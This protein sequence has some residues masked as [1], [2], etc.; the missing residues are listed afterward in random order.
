MEKQKKSLVYL[1]GFM[2]SGKSTIA[3]ILA[4]TIGYDTVDIDTE[5]EKV[6]GKKVSEI[7]SD[8]GEHFF[9]ETERKLL[10]EISRRQACVVSLG[11]GT[12][13]NDENLQLVKATGVLV[14]LKTDIEHII[15][16]MKFKR[17][18]PLLKTQEGS[19]L[20][21]DELRIR[22]NFLLESREPFYNQAD[23]T[24]PT[25]EAR[26]GLTVDELVRSLKWL[27]E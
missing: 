20:P 6:T 23:L 19:L 13:A 27:I 8:L 7:F 4:N 17:D 10:H 3:P 14:Y 12:I 22:I 24:I 18:R 11:G 26:V 15:Q 16:R 25:N 2:G 9:R 1:A 21:D 5:I